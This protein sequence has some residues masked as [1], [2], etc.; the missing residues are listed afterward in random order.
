LQ[1]NVTTNP[2]RTGRGFWW[3]S[4]VLLA[5]VGLADSIYLTYVKLVASGVCVAGN[6]CETVNLSPYSQIGAVPVAL[7]GALSYGAML[8]ILFLENSSEF[9]ELN[10][11]LMMFG[12]TFFGVLYSA[13][14]TY[15]EIYVIKAICLFCVVSAIVLVL[16]LIISSLRLR[17]DFKSS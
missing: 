15:L 5:L 13:Y 16:M 6:G 12:L 8:V 14:L 9:F 3:Y 2:Q 11:P 10:S 1:K 17:A 4:L 7:L